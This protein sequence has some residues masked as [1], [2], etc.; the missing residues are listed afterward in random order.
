[1]QHLMIDLETYGTRPGAVIRSIGAVI[2]DDKSIGKEFYT[3]LTT[4]DQIAKGCH[5]D[6]GTVDWWNRQS[7]E[8]QNQLLTNQQSFEVGM[9]QF[10][11]FYR[12][13][14]PTFV[15]SQGSNFD[16]VLLDRSF[17]LFGMKIP[18]RFYNTRDTRTIYHVAGLDIK[19]IIRD[20]TYH[21]SLDDA[22]HQILCVQE[23]L[24]RIRG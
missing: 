24:R 13:N 9:N 8:A 5:V 1:M 20:G 16:S 17:E 4:E 12:S 11:T 18:W 3:N 15:W 14:K 23:S 10:L 21:N 6:Q 7:K 22:K 19:T 2:F